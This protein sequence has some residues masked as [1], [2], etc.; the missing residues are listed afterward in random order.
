MAY[1]LK[2]KDYYDNLL[3]SQID[4][5]NQST[6][7]AKMPYQYNISQAQTIYQPTRNEAY[8]SMY[9]N[10]RALR[11][12][13]ANYGLGAQGG[14][15]QKKEAGIVNSLK[16]QLTN[17][18]LAQQGYVNQQNMGISQINTQNQ[19]NVANLTAQNQM[20]YQNALLSQQ[21][22]QNTMY[23]DLLNRGLITWKKYL[24]LTGLQL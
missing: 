2:I 9:A 1:V 22:S 7:A 11:E 12:R 8:T 17:T 6:E 4:A 18:D 19:A 13:M 14:T 3:K 24:E 5:S 21:Q 20:D 16:S 10:Q 23:R 15:S